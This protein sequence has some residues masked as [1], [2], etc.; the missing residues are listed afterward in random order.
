MIRYITLC[1]RLP[2]V[3]Y[4][5]TSEEFVKVPTVD[6]AASVCKFHQNL[7]DEKDLYIL[8]SVNICAGFKAMH[9]ATTH[10]KGPIHAAG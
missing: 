3:S 6:N 10:L 2:L 7:I 1:R 9:P 8:S 4:A 5:Y